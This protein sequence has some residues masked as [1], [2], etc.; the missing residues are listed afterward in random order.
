M[1]LALPLICQVITEAFPQYQVELR[2]PTDHHSAMIT[3][4][5]GNE[6]VGD[7]EIDGGELIWWG[8]IND[9]ADDLFCWFSL[10]DPELIP[11]IVGI[12]KKSIPMD[13]VGQVDGSS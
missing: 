7:F 2:P 4:E 8:D 5:S 12:V 11:K 6:Y 1:S 13:L 3:V 9:L 10:S